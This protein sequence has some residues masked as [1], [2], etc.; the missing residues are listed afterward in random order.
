MPLL[1]MNSA[2]TT[3]AIYAFLF[4]AQRLQSYGSV[5]S[6]IR[7]ST[8]FS[9]FWSSVAS[10]GA[11][12]QNLRFKCF[13]QNDVTVPAIQGM[14]PMKFAH[15]FKVS[16]SVTYYHAMYVLEQLQLL[17]KLMYRFQ[18]ANSYSLYFC[19][20]ECSL[21]PHAGPGHTCCSTVMHPKFKKLS[22]CLGP[23]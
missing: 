16:L 15:A 14:W 18:N 2:T 11:T 22:F 20:T 3:A 4:S 8:N 5:V 7:C 19:V 17:R 23:P 12:L 21:C 10:I 6:W 9:L 13:F 1:Q